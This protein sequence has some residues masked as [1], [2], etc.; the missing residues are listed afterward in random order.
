MGQTYP[1]IEILLIDDGSPD[2]AGTIC[3]KYAAQDTRIRVF[4]IPNG[5]VAKARQL[6][7]E[8][9]TGEYIVFVDPD[10]WL[11]PDSLEKLYA[12]IKPEIDIVIGGYRTIKGNLTIDNIQKKQTQDNDTYTSNLLLSNIYPAPWGKLYRK[13]IFSANSF[14]NAKK[15][16]DLLMNIEISERIRMAVLIDNC[17]YNYYQHSQSTIATHNSNFQYEKQFAQQAYSILK[18]S[19]REEKYARQMVHFNLLRIYIAIVQGGQIPN[20]DQWVKEVLHNSKT[21]RLSTKE[22]IVRRAATRPHLQKLI[23]LFRA[24]L[25]G[26]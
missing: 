15:G 14:P 23:K 8:N 2:N 20:N 22:K 3:D 25:K 24:L 18:T 21:V 12:G 9:S 6:G 16:Q 17:I 1:N 13:S 7:V 5:G 10:D 11:N 4:H 19:K 26:E